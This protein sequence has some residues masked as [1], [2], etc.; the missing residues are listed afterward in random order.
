MHIVGISPLIW[1]NDRIVTISGFRKLLSLA[2]LFIFHIVF[3]WMVALAISSLQYTVYIACNTA[4]RCLYTVWTRFYMFCNNVLW[5]SFQTVFPS[6]IV[7]WTSLIHHLATRP[8]WTLHLG[9]DR[10][11]IFWS[12]VTR[13]SIVLLIVLDM[14]SVLGSLSP[15]TSCL[16]FFL[17]VLVQ[18]QP[19]EAVFPRYIVFPVLA[20]LMHYILWSD[21]E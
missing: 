18:F 15:L 20:M 16:I 1:P 8:P 10:F 17:S 9:I 12:Y 6:D 21:L 14:A 13:I 11:A 4:F 2:H 7:S 5:Y 19:F 3:G